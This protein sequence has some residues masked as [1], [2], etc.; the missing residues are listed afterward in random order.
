MEDTMLMSYVLDAG[1]NRHN[2]D[3]LAQIHLQHKNISFK[4][5]VGTGKKQL[6]FSEVNIELAKDYAAEDSDVTFRLYKI[7]YE[8][9][10]SE[11]LLQIYENFEKPMIEILAQMEIY[12]IKIDNKFLKQL[13]NKFATKIDQLEKDIFKIT[14]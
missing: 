1:K 11:K 14:K 3:N 12:G 9:L 4:E 6:N 10:V 7:F 2:L 5:L 8:N 13:S